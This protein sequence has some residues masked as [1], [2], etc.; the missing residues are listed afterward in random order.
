[1]TS[2]RTSVAAKLGLDVS[3]TAE[4]ALID[5]YINEGVTDVVLRTG[6]D[7]TSAT[8]TETSGAGDYTLDAAILRIR[9]LQ[10]ASGSYYSLPERVSIEEILAL[11]QTNTAASTTPVCYAIEGSNLLMVYPTPS[12]SD[13]LTVYYVPRPLTLS[14]GTDTP[15]EIPLEFHKAVELYALSELADYNDDQSSQDGQRYLQQYEMWIRRIKIAVNLK[16]GRSAR[17]QVGS[18][19]RRYAPHTNDRY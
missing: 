9:G 18:R 4:L 14:G 8:L 5:Q 15:S 11:R 12:A 2:F 19:V 1:M 6:C 17:A 10:W 13:T 3:S 16:G 7:V